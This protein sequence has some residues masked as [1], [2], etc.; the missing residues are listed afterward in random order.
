MHVCAKAGEGFCKPYRAFRG[1]GNKGLV[2]FITTLHDINE[3]ET[4]QIQVHY[5]LRGGMPVQV[6]AEWVEILRRFYN[7]SPCRTRRTTESVFLS[8]YRM[9]GRSHVRDGAVRS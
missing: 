4:I 1:E 3:R 2:S 6:S 7:S 9:P 5:D 8:Y